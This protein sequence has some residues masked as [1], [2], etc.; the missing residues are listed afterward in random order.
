MHSHQHLLV[1][2]SVCRLSLK[3]KSRNEIVTLVVVNVVVLWY[4][5]YNTD[6]Y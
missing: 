1:L 3:V 6:N 2:C 4:C 5:N